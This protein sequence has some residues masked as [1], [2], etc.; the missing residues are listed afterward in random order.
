[1]KKGVLTI[2]N[3]AI[4]ATVVFGQNLVPNY[5]FEQYTTCPNASSQINF[6]S[7]WYGPTNNSTEYLNSCS[8]MYN[9]SIAG[10]GQVPRTGN[11]YAAMWIFNGIPDYKEYL[12]VGLLDTLRTD[13]CYYVEFYVC[14]L[15]GCRF[16]AN[17]IG[18]HFSQDTIWSTGTGYYL[19][20]TPDILL[21]GNPI[22]SDTSNWVK[23]YGNYQANG[24]EKF[25]T[26]GNFFSDANTD[27]ISILPFPNYYGSYYLIDDVSV[28]K[29]SQMG[30]IPNNFNNE[31]NL[32][33]NPFS[34]ATTLSSNSS[35]K[36]AELSIYDYHGNL[37]KQISNINGSSFNLQREN[38]SAGLY[39]L[40]LTQKDKLFRKYKIMI[41]DN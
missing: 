29:C 1:M 3:L 23:I 30:L 6:A 20:I 12:Q 40:Q 34:S 11:A 25:I 37:M 14:L 5:S 18:A 21:P 4:F 31:I 22:I 17:N 38:L 7:P 39:F 36:D 8:A 32:F 19:N 41:S 9:P 33:P 15:R 26:I 10:A 13:S 16:A 28:V 27:T 35:F 2:F 24:G